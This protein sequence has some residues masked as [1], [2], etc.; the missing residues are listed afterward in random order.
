MET[1]SQAMRAELEQYMSEHPC[2]DCGGKRLKKETLAVT[3]GGS[4]IAD[5]TDKS[6]IEAL[7]FVNN[8]KLTGKDAVIA[9]VIL[10]K[11]GKAWILRSV[12]L[13]YSDHKQECRQPV[14]R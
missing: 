11:S 8:L 6:N 14:R 2:P 4:N 3:V 9:N 1:Q 7:D 10:K 12:G 5:F 13:E